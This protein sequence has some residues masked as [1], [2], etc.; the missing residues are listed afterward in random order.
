VH[1]CTCETLAQ[2]HKKSIPE[3]RNMWG[4]FTTETATPFLEVDFIGSDFP[5]V[6]LGK[7]KVVH[8]Q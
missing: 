3:G 6:I 2:G 7:N 8:D 4:A 1:L 5:E